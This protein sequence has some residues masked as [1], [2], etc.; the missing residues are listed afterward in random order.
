MTNHINTSGAV[1]KWAREKAGLSTDKASELSG[2][3]REALKFMETIVFDSKADV[4]NEAINVLSKELIGKNYVYNKEGDIYYIY[5]KVEFTRYYKVKG[6]N[7][8]EADYLLY[9]KKA[10]KCLY[11][12]NLTGYNRHKFFTDKNRN[13]ILRYIISYKFNIFYDYFDLYYDEID[14]FGIGANY[15]HRLFTPEIIFEMVKYVDNFVDT[16]FNTSDDNLLKFF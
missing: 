10:D 1:L 6:C 16:Y 2:I 3:P 13:R 5:D 8:N 7:N 4:E 12:Y 11:F 14:E 15:K 9:D